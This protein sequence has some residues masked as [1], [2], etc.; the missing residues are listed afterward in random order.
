MNTHQP[1]ILY[2]HVCQLLHRLDACCACVLQGMVCGAAIYYHTYLIF[3]SKVP[4]QNPAIIP[5]AGRTIYMGYAVTPVP[6]YLPSLYT[7]VLCSIQFLLYLNSSIIPSRIIA[8]YCMC[9]A[10]FLRAG[11]LH[12]SGSRG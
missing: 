12:T 1:V 4:G 6:K 9:N 8:I 11:S 7:P 2:L 3:D 10:A 5:P